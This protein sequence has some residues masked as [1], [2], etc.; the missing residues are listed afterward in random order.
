MAYTKTYKLSKEVYWRFFSHH[1][2]KQSEKGGT[3]WK[4]ILKASS[5]PGPELNE[6]LQAARLKV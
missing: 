4:H 2:A 5:S 6:I 3:E 1:R